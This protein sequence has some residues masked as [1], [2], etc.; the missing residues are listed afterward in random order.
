M[1]EHEKKRKEKLLKKGE[2]VDEEDKD[3]W[4]RPW[5]ITHEEDAEFEVKRG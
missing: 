1:S 3:A 2:T 5:L 4:K